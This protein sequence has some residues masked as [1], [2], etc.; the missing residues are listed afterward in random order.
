LVFKCN[1][2]FC[3][4]VCTSSKPTCRAQVYNSIRSV[5]DVQ[6]VTEQPGVQQPEQHH[7]QVHDQV[8]QHVHVD[9]IH[10]HDHGHSHEHVHS[11]DHGH[12]HSHDHGHG[13]SH[14]HHHHLRLN[15]GN[16]SGVPRQAPEQVHQAVEQTLQAVEPP[17]QAVEPLQQAIDQNF[18]PIE[19]P[20][21][22]VEQNYLGVEPPQ[23]GVDQN[24]QGV[25]PPQQ[26]VDQN[27]QAVEP[28]QQAEI[29]QHVEQTPQVVQL[30]PDQSPPAVSD[31]WLNGSEAVLPIE[32]TPEVRP[33]QINPDDVAHTASE[34]PEAPGLVEEHMS[35]TVEP[36]FVDLDHESVDKRDEFEEVESSQFDACL[37]LRSKQV[38]KLF[39]K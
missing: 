26:A 21:Q 22:A 15:F 18:Q 27:Y 29:E 19:P 32:A 20:Q 1:L 16:P 3:Q 39:K 37:R 13:H 30:P 7:H 17:Q 31:E 4:V 6:P 33:E 34:V 25:E 38:T 28:P 23:Q 9:Q 24:Y 11:H 14:G 8:E 12:G 36:P 2:K 10:S 5:L 35:T